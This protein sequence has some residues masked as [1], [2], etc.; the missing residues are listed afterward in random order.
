MISKKEI[1]LYFFNLLRKWKLTMKGNISNANVFCT[2]K[3]I[4]RVLIE[5][6]NNA[7]RWWKLEWL[8]SNNNNYFW[9]PQK[10]LWKNVFCETYLYVSKDTNMHTSKDSKVIYH[11][12]IYVICL[13]YRY[14]CVKGQWR[15]TSL[16]R[17]VVKVIL[18]L[19]FETKE[20]TLLGPL[21]AT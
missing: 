11:T 7:T 21:Q 16:L 18:L 14:I 9:Q 19:P 10:V 5:M 17:W 20:T 3:C 8:P 12:S 2:F 13:Y 1:W 4:R 15:V 6:T